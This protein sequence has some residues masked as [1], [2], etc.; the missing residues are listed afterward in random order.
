MNKKKTAKINQTID[1]LR[2]KYNLSKAMN[3]DEL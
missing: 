2:K 1:Q 3:M